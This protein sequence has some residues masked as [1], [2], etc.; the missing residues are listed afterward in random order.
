MTGL[1][2]PLKAKDV[3][4]LFGISSLTLRQWLRAGRFP[5]PLKIGRRQRY[6]AAADVERAQAGG[7]P[8]GKQRDTAMARRH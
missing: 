3:C 2:Q 8:D 7:M 5:A 1:E 4:E 6:W